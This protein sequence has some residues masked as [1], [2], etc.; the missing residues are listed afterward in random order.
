MR[1]WWLY[2]CYSVDGLYLCYRGLNL[3]YS[4][5][6]SLVGYT[7]VTLL[8]RHWWAKPVLLA[9]VGYTCV[10]LLTRHWWAIPVLLC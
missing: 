10:T 8:T 4:V 7:C 9:L 2:L 1:H 3:C 6:E 5:D